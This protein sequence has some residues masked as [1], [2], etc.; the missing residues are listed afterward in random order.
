M[1]MKPE[2]RE[3]F[4]GVVARLR[5]RLNDLDAYLYP[6]DGGSML[7]GEPY[8]LV[9]RDCPE[10]VLQRIDRSLVIGHPGD[11]LIGVPHYSLDTAKLQ[12]DNVRVAWG[13]DLVPATARSW[14]AQRYDELAEMIA[15]IE[16]QIE[17]EA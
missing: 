2:A 13:I 6:K 9:Q 3:H 10:R 5:Q 4:E 11:M 16:E 15:L 7:V 17:A 8:I 14:M 12:A 1:T